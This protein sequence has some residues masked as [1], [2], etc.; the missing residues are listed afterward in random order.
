MRLLA[1]LSCLVKH[2]SR[3]FCEGVHRCDSHLNW[4]TSNKSRL[5]SIMCL[6]LI[7][8]VE[9]LKRKDRGCLKKKQFCLK[10][11]TRN[12]AWVSSLLPCRIWT[13]DCNITSCQNFQPVGLPYRFLTGQTPQMWANF[14]KSLSLSL[15]L[16][17]YICIYIYIYSSRDIS[18]WFLLNLVQAPPV[19]SK[20]YTRKKCL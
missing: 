12:P 1:R 16:S 8:S 5:P 17:L 13:Q 9:G 11:G 6:D 3:C 10:T 2:Y 20:S 7:Q 15:S 19:W 14:L 4:S 18:Y